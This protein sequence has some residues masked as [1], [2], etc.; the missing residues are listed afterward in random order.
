MRSPRTAMR[1]PHTAMKSSPR[2]PQLEKARTQQGRPTAAKN[3]LINLKKNKKKRITKCWSRVWRHSFQSLTLG[4]QGYKQKD[5]PV[6]STAKTKVSSLNGAK[7]TDFQELIRSQLGYMLLKSK[8]KSSE[9]LEV[10]ILGSNWYPWHSS[11]FR[12]VRRNC[13]WKG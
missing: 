2:S 3:K 7:E 10:Y 8:S 5:K 11:F 13:D 1:S 12:V 6:K 9:V 4:L